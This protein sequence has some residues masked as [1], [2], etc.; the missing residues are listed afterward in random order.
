[1]PEAKGPTNDDR[2]IKFL[3]ESR[4]ISGSD[5]PGAT[6]L[7]STK[8]VK[9]SLLLYNKKKPPPPIPEL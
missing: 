8:V 7:A 9:L 4:Y 6:S 2:G 3:S 5:L 1:M